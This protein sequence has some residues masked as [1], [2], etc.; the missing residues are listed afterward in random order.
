MQQRCSN[1]LQQLGGDGLPVLKLQLR[2]WYSCSA[3]SSLPTSTINQSRVVAWMEAGSG[4]ID[5][6]Q[7][8]AADLPG[9]GIPGSRRR[10]HRLLHV[11]QLGRRRHGSSPRAPSTPASPLLDTVRCIRPLPAGSVTSL[12]ALTT[13]GARFTW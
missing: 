7:Y 1:R 8:K 10:G 9:L 12:A 4:D 3:Q 11:A 5:V 2:V 13:A 6:C